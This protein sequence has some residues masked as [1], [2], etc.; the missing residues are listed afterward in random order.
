MFAVLI[1][2]HVLICLALMLSVLLQTG[3]GTGLASAFGGAGGSESMFGGRGAAS[4]LAKATTALAIL[5]MVSSASLAWLSAHRRQE[6]T[7]IEREM[8]RTQE[9]PAQETGIPS[10]APPLEFG[11]GEEEVEGEGGQ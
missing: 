5:F 4:I 6:M 1:G 8:Q 2:I 10:V 11:E 3:K 7:A 9:V